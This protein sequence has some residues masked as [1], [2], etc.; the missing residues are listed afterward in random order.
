MDGN[1]RY[2]RTNGMKLIQGHIDG[3]VALRRVRASHFP[4]LEHGPGTNLTR[5]RPRQVLEICSSL[6]VKFVSVYAFAIDNFK[7]PREEVDGLMHLAEN[8]L[9]ELCTHGCVVS[10]AVYWE[11]YLWPFGLEVCSLSMEC[12]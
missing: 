5:Q 2:A 6:D 11:F 9:L 3:F 4:P 1:R 8:A 10:S 12:G 7:R